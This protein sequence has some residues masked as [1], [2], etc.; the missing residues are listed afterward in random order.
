VDANDVGRRGSGSHCGWCS[1]LRLR[2][3]GWTRAMS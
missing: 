2:G 1:A 3:G